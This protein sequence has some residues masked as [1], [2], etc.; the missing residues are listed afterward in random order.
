MPSCLVIQHAAPERCFAIGEAL[1][2]QGVDI[3]VRRVHASEPLPQRLGDDVDGVVV[4][5]GPMSATSDDRFPTHGQ[6]IALLTAAVEAGLPVLGVCLGAQL[7][8]VAAGGRVFR[9][10]AGAEIGWAPVRFTTAAA[11]DPLFAAAPETLTVL[12]WH[13]ET[14]ELPAGAVHLAWSERY[15]QQAFRVGDRAWGLQF[16]LEV[17]QVA[18]AEFVDVFGEEAVAAGTSPTAIIAGAPPALEAL[19]PHRREILA[20]FAALVAAASG[21][22]RRGPVGQGAEL[23]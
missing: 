5:G 15:P 14:Y 20:R 3:D 6:E 22:P 23:V 1:D 2:A 21:S 18:V 10:A 13:G 4:M 12:H 17:D 8:A 7:L 11:A 9:G 16:H 19:D